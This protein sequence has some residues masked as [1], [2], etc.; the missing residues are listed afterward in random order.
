MRGKGKERQNNVL[1]ICV[2]KELAN[3]L[4][5]FQNFINYNSSLTLKISSDCLNWDFVFNF[6]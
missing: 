4:F 3:W 2:L 6:F 5:F 1:Y